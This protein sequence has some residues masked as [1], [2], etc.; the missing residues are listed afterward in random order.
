MRGEETRHAGEII[1]VRAKAM[2]Q[3]Q[4]L[5][6]PTLQIHIVHAIWQFDL[7]AHQP[8]ALAL[9]IDGKSQHLF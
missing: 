2:Q 4:G 9:D 3:Q 8:R 6:L 7:L 1:L 5:A